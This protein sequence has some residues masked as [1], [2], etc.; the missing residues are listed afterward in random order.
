ML[1]IGIQNAPLGVVGLQKIQVRVPLVPNN[2]RKPVHPQ[3]FQIPSKKQE[4]KRRSKVAARPETLWC[5]GN[6]DPKGV[7]FVRLEKVLL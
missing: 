5:R 4:G 7:R 1:N 2:L 6:R 3:L